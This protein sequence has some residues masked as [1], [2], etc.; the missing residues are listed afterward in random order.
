VEFPWDE[1]QGWKVSAYFHDLLPAEKKKGEKT[2]P[3]IAPL[4]EERFRGKR[5]LRS[6]FAIMRKGKRK[7]QSISYTRAREYRKRKRHAPRFIPSIG[8]KGK[9]GRWP[10]LLRKK[11]KKAEGKRY[12]EMASILTFSIF[13]GGVKNHL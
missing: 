5:E 6:F 7:F 8:I 11:E 4:R 1:I 10:R 12:Q 9:K 3:F 2:C 13:G